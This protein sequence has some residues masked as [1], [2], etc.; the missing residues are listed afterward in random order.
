[1]GTFDELYASLNPNPRTRGFEAEKVCRW[2]LET[3]PTYASLLRR[4]WLWKVWPGR[5]S[6]VD[7]GIDLVAED[8]AG[9]LW[10]IQVKA[11]AEHRRIPKRELDSFLSESG[12]LAFGYRLLITTSAAGLHRIAAETVAAQE[13]PVLLVDLADLRKSP[14]DWPATLED[15][16]LRTPAIEI[17]N[18]LLPL[19]TAEEFVEALRVRDPGDLRFEQWMA[20]L[21]RFVEAHGHARVPADYSVDGQRLGRWVIH[22]RQRWARGKLS[23]ARLQRLQRLPGW[24]F[25]C[26]EAAWLDNYHQLTLFVSTHGS[27]SVHVDFEGENG[28]C[29][30]AWI[31]N[32]RIKYAGGR[33]TKHRVRLLEAVPGWTWDRSSTSTAAAA[34]R[35]RGGPVGGPGQ[36]ATCGMHRGVT[37]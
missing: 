9:K 3:D 35:F 12:R 7:A 29:L 15:L 13:K 26:H 4:V 8:T 21:E 27:P 17:D 6:D 37:T 36:A 1:M 18:A 16:P 22:Q 32:Q 2:F 19:S 28:I 10:A 20:L 31:V 33:L 25:N 34:E 24:A 5:W 30:A 11:P 14:V 23:P